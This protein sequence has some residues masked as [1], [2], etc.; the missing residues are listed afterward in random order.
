MWK[1]RKYEERVHWAAQLD[2]QRVP[3]VEGQVQQVQQ[4]WREGWH[5]R[6]EGQGARY[7]FTGLR[8]MHNDRSSARPAP[9]MHK[10]ASTR[11][12]IEVSDD[13]EPGP[14]RAANMRCGRFL[15]AGM[16]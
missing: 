2:V 3:E 15:H 4:M 7:V 6:G 5:Q 11:K 8:S 16:V 12:T 1:V 9:K 14:S 10:K 13:D